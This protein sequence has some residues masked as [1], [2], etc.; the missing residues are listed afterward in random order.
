MTRA[1]AEHLIQESIVKVLNQLSQDDAVDI[2]NE[3]ANLFNN[4][5]HY[6]TYTPDRSISYGKCSEKLSFQ[7]RR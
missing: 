1:E 7:Q 5:I 2:C 3:L 6:R 4:R